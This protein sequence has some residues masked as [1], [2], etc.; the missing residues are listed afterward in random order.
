MN[1][2]IEKLISSQP[3]SNLYTIQSYFKPFPM[4]LIESED[5]L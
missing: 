4:K 1:F 3:F 2:L 5:I